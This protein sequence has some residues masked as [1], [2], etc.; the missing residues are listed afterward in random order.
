MQV[1]TPQ[2][3]SKKKV[4]LRLDLDVPLVR[5]S[6][7]WVV[8]DDFRLRAGLE[9]LKLCLNH[10]SSV[11]ILGHL[12]RPSGKEVPE[13]S[14]TPIIN[15]LESQPTQKN[16]PQGKIHVL[17]NLRFK[18]GE[19]SQ[20]EQFAKEL[21][22]LG[23]VFV[24]ESFAAYHK[25]SSTTVLPT[26]LPHAAGLRFAKEVEVLTRVRENPKKPLVVII[27]GVKVEDKLP[28]IEVMS[29]IADAVLVGGKLVS[30]L[31]G[32]AGSQPQNL[33]TA[34]TSAGP[35]SGA[36]RS[37]SPAFSYPNILVGKLN[38]QGT[39]IAPET[40]QSWE[41]VIMNAKMILWNGPMG[42]VEED[43][44]DQTRLIA[45]MVIKSRAESIVG[46]GDTIAAL[47]KWGLRDKFSFIST[48]GGAMLKF[49]ADGTL[50]TIEAL[51]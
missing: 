51:Q 30:E 16:L 9:T 27:G 13:L 22:A 29:K 31:A 19:E 15:W 38:K 2:F 50:P 39:D 43:Q 7:R 14:V 45:Q 12:G 5:K 37:P 32:P 6:D 47:T 1:V 46:G 41:K 48:G 8:A 44:N 18:A 35:H 49:L 25:A 34:L 36:P 3:V 11:V 40:T 21:A 26:L 33:P 17:E 23:D 28:A 10:A 42:R 4:L 24:N 20:D